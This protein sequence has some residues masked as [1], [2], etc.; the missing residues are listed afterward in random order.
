MFNAVDIILFFSYVAT[1]VMFVLLIDLKYAIKK[2]LIAFSIFVIVSY[3][4]FILLHFYQIIPESI[5]VSILAVPAAIFSF[6]LAKYRDSR[7]LFTLFTAD[8]LG[9]IAYLYARTLSIPFADNSIIIIVGAFVF[10]GILFLL[11]SKYR[12]TFIYMQNHIKSGWL[13]MAEFSIAAYILISVMANYPTRIIDRVVDLPILILVTLFIDFTF[14]I[15]YKL[16]S[17]DIQIY[18]EKKEFAMLELDNKYQKSQLELQDVY[19][20]YAYEDVMT[21]LKNRRAFEELKLKKL[22]QSTLCLTIDINNLKK[23]NDQKGHQ[24][25]DLALTTLAHAIKQTF[26]KHEKL[27]RIGG[28]EFVLII[29]DEQTNDAAYY[30]EKIKSNLKNLCDSSSC[31]VTVAI[32]WSSSIED[33]LESIAEMVELADQR[34]Y[35]QKRNINSVKKVYT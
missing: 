10:Y 28:D 5:P 1:G 27:Y 14:V 35:E 13:I 25:G 33:G 21:T 12:S 3:G 18:N 34:M 6:F 23:I 31:D 19:Y 26:H 17:K 7:F 16:V 24:A 4:L 20:R 32:G 9:F 2:S 11:I 22:T 15:I 29:D 30:N 8:T